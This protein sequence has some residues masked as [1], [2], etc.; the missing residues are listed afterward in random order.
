MEAAM[1]SCKPLWKH[2]WHR[3]TRYTYVASTNPV[4]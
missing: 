3:K 4:G 2:A 1:L